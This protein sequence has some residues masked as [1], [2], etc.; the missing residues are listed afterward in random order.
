M[1]TEE[2][3]KELDELLEIE[4]IERLIENLNVID[5]DKNP[6]Y[7]FLYESITQQKYDLRGELIGGYAGCILEGSSRSGKTW[8]GVDII[9]WLCTHIETDCKINIYRSTFAEFKDTLYDDFKRRLDDFNLPNPFHNAQVVRSFKIGRNIISFKGCDKLGKTHGAGADYVFYNEMIDIPKGVFDQSE[10]RCRKFWWADYNPSVTEHYIFDNIIPRPDVGW[11]RTT[12]LHNPHLSPAE[13]NKI[14]GYE[15]WEPG[16]YEV[17]EKDIFYQGQ[18]VSETNQPPINEFNVRNGTADEFMWRVYGLGL[19][20]AMKGVIFPNVTWI[21]QFPDLPAIYPT[22]FGF[23]ADPHVTGKYAEDEH[24]IYIEP[25]SYKPIE[26]PEEISALWEALDIP[27]SGVPLPC[28]S[29]DRFVSEHRGAIE[30]VTQLQELGW[31]DCYKIQKRKSVMFWIMSMKQKKIHI[32]RNHLYKEAKKEQEN[33]KM[34]EVNGIMI[35]QPIDK[36]NHLWDMA[37]Y[38]HIAHNDVLEIDTDWG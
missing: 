21:D 8:S 7:K 14:L 28:D 4:R 3:L 32:V 16:T 10:M 15:P 38:G 22:D 2:E 29:A 37:R 5:D 11:L 34:K 23:T 1:L 30:M 18:P 33:Y 6:N 20:G 9:I 13:K 26:T 25:L 17:T 35:N 27:K 36:W 24:N 19:R 31:V 12:F